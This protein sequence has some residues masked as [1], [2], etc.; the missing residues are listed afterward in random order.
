MK[1]YGQIINMA[2]DYIEANLHEKILLSDIAKS[3]P[4]SEYHF[5][6]IFRSGSR[7]TTHQFISRVKLER[8]AVILVTDPSLSITEVAY[9]YGYGESSSSCRAFRKHFQTSPSEYR[10]ARIVKKSS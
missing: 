6:R 2:E 9:R 3:I 7:E 8:S 10:S 1:T 4:M 5:H